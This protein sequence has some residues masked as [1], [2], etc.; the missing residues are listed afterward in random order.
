MR[1]YRVGQCQL[2]YTFTEEA[3][4]LWRVLHNRH[5]LDGYALMSLDD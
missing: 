4:T 2:F 3:L 1:T 5:D